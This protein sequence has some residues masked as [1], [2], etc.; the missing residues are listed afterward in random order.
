MKLFG[1]IIRTAVNVATLPVAV[2]KDIVTLGGTLTGDNDW[3]LDETFT[4]KKVDQ[5]KEEAKEG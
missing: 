1:Q 4:A 5:I 2:V 3:S